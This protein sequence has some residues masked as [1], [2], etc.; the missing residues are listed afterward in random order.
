M[1][2]NSFIT[3]VS[4][5]VSRKCHKQGCSEF[6]VRMLD[7]RIQNF[8]MIVDNIFE[9]RRLLATPNPTPI[10]TPRPNQPDPTRRP[11]PKPNIT[12]TM[13]PTA[14]IEKTNPNESPSIPGKYESIISA[15]DETD[16]KVQLPTFPPNFTVGLISLEDNAA[17]TEAYRLAPLFIAS[18]LLACLL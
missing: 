6:E 9:L 8:Y 4:R 17:T 15:T 13:N 3:T 7:E 18:I 10:P 5:I 1:S 11:T 16:N 12:K 14:E 2:S